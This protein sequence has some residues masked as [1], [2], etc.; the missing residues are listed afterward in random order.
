MVHVKMGCGHYADAMQGEPCHREVFCSRCIDITTAAFH[1]VD[2]DIE[3]D[4]I[5]A[6]IREKTVA[7]KERNRLIE[8]Q[9]DILREGKAIDLYMQLSSA[10]LPDALH[11][12]YIKN[13]DAFR[14]GATKGDDESNG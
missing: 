3:N 6:A 4:P 12:L 7:D 11:E 10:K 8:A 1:V 14:E 13:I 2:Y 9:T 5:A